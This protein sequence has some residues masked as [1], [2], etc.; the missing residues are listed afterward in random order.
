MVRQLSAKR[1]FVLTAIGFA[2]VLGCSLVAELLHEPVPRIHDEFSYVLMSNTF[3]SGR[4]ANP[5]PP[6]PEFFDTFHILMRPV[7]ASKYFPAQ[8][9]FLA[10]G[11]K[12]TGHPS[13]GVWLSSGVA[14]AAT[15]WMLQAWAG[16]TWGLLGGFLMMVQLGIFSYW[17][18]TY[19]GGMAAAL[20]G[21]LF[22]GA[23]RRLWHRLTWPNAIW[24]SIGLV[25]LANSR[26]S[27]GFVA[28]LPMAVVLLRQICQ[29]GQLKEVVFWRNLILPALLILLPAAAAMAGYNHAITTDPWKPPYVLH[30]QQYQESPQFTFLPLRPKITY[31]SPWLQ[32]YYEVNEMKL[33]FSQRTSKNLLLTAVPKL[34]EWWKFYCGV[35]LMA[36]LVL[37]ALLRKGW[38]RYLQTA[39]LLAFVCAAVVYQP[40]SEGLR[41]MI[42][43]LVLG[44]VVVLWLVFGGQWPRLALGTSLLIIFESFFVKWARPHYF[45]P[46]AC[47]VLFLQVEGLRFIWEWH[48][49]PK[50]S[51]GAT[52]SERRRA[53]RAKLQSQPVVSPWRGFV[54]LLPLACLISLAFQIGGRM[55]D[56]WNDEDEHGATGRVLP[57]HDWSL[58]RADLEHWLQ[59]QSRPQ[60][61][62]VRYFPNHNVNFEWVYNHAD[63]THSHVIWARDLG[64]DHNKLLLEEFPNR[65]SW[66]LDADSEEPQ[67]V[68]YGQRPPSDVVSIQ[69]QTSNQEDH[70]NW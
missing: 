51:V 41:F 29:T 38:I 34:L 48:R 25:I 21:A 58:R 44:Q 20:G 59:Q 35:L 47:L 26:P 66:L 1:R 7:Y 15:C 37:P 30:E 5:T 27:E 28:I 4:I 65:T 22:F 24:M 6:L 53:H 31:S 62:F 42:D 68:P 52:R 46:A 14:C 8:G 32:H 63:L 57:L 36:P 10:L 16:P 39:L 33:Y 61:V 60:L 40:R 12:L 49:E 17:S 9:L 50:L 70:L 67:L 45:A 54:I 3:A 18:Q 56:W 2:T 23:A 43:F 69:D 13:V 11:E 64:A 19:W 55:N